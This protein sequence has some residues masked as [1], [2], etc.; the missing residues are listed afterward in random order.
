MALSSQQ[1]ERLPDAARQS[2]LVVAVGASR[3]REAFAELFGYFAPR[4]K[5]YLLRRGAAPAE[6]EPDSRRA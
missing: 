6:A 4:I 2:Q 5:A 1:A 3:D